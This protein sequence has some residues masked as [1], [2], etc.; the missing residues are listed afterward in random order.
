MYLCN[1]PVKNGFISTGRRHC[2][3]DW[4]VVERKSNYS[5]LQVSL[6][7]AG[8]SRLAASSRASASGGVENSRVSRA[9]K[10]SLH[11]HRGGGAL[12]PPP[13]PLAIAPPLG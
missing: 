10:W 9:E 4:P 7:D 12:T 5:F 11:R 3:Y 8:G 2:K 6:A 1:C 13:N